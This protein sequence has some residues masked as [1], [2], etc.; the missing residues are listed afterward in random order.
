MRVLDLS[1]DLAGRYGA[2]L[3]ADHGFEVIGV[4]LPRASAAF[5]MVQAAALRSVDMDALRDHLNRN[6]T[7]ISLD[8]AGGG[9]PDLDA[10]IRGADVVVHTFDAE[11][12]RTLDLGADRIR[13]LN[14]R[15][16]LVTITSYGHTVPPRLASEKTLYADGG[17][18]LISGSPDA[19]FPLAPNLPIPSTIGA[20]YAAMAVLA[21]QFGVRRGEAPSKHIDIA[22]RDLLP[23]SLE[24]V[25]AFYTYMKVNPFRGT[26]RERI[27]QAA[28]MGD[29]QAKDGGFHV[30]GQEDPYA[31]IAEL[32]G[33]PELVE[34]EGWMR[35]HTHKM[36]AEAI[37]QI[38]AEGVARQT[39]AELEAKGRELG[40]PT[41]P[42]REIDELAGL[43]QIRHRQA[44]N[45]TANGVEIEEPYRFARFERPR[46]AERRV[47]SIGEIPAAR[48]AAS[49]AA[50][51]AAPRAGPGPLAGVRVL[52]LTHA[53]AGPS[54]TRILSDLGAEVI[55]VESVTHMDSVP[56]G[57]LPFDNDP[58]EIW[59]ERSGYFAD[60]NLGKKSLTLDMGS[61]E[62]REIFL[63]LLDKVDVVA[64][65]FRPRV[66]TRWGL[67]PDVLLARKPDLVVLAMSGFGGDGPDSEKPALAGLIEATSG[68]T[69]MMR[70]DDGESPVEV[71]FAF[72]DMIS[73]LYAT[74]SVLMALDRRDR[75]G[76]GEAID[77][78][79]CEAPLPV[80]AVQL[81]QWARTGRRPSV[82]DE[83]VAGGRH[84]L[85]R[86]K[87]DVEPERWALVFVRP[88]QEVVATA[89]LGS[90]RPD[91]SVARAQAG[92]VA[93]MRA[94]GLAVAPLS[95]AE[96]LIFDPE[97]EARG[98]FQ[99]VDRPSTGPLPYASAFPALAD[100]CPMGRRDL[101]PPP[102]LGEHAAAVLAELLDVTPSGYEDLVARD[103]TGTVPVGKQKSFMRWPIRLDELERRGRVRTADGA[104]EKL[105]EYFKYPL[106][107]PP[108]KSIQK[109]EVK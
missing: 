32:I 21:Q 102:R 5:A 65:N 108:E 64:T 66:M 91:C 73:G 62:G 100:G 26:R 97:L 30:F 79:C 46:E 2:R 35:P 48:G 40:M 63:S 23:I 13:A 76:K 59:W 52:D 77:L 6:K 72:G 15:A 69:S 57:L 25:L 85:V 89:I 86:T 92:F 68:F 28:A 98:L 101:G 18:T 49:A 39:V 33:R 19:P 55:K 78:S 50:P 47:G 12:A 27:D 74:L 99:V 37:R 8:Y 96:Q 44:L 106:R 105:A 41:G 9:R 36:S 10:L 16:T 56:R 70:Y 22:L 29:F 51:T 93:D 95:N 80:L 81:H 71:G 60:R 20:I 14:P 34:E 24:R 75:D 94:M 45:R 3:L 83:I 109:D 88:D 103:L 61:P 43:P 84:V 104:A 54:S 67:G 87:G 4:E 7:L 42:I 58:T 90:D 17:G 11:V 31:K 107:K 82:R 38:V 53:Y 1:F